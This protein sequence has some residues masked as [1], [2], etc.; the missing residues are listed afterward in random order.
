MP[1]HVD[2]FVHILMLILRKLTCAMACVQALKLSEAAKVL[3]TL[4]SQHSL[5]ELRDCDAA[6]QSKIMKTSLARLIRSNPPPSDT[7]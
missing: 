4:G 6:A 7:R 5:A 2:C 3:K 1:F